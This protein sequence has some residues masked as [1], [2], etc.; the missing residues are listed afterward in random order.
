MKMIDF[1]GKMDQNYM[2][3]LQ[4][5]RN[6]FEIISGDFVVKAFYSFTYKN[7]LCFVLEYMVGGDFNQILKLY[8]ALD[9]V[10]ILIG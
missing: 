9:E 10:N 2:K 6:I 8:C 3:T 5:E 4:A 7:Y 1:T